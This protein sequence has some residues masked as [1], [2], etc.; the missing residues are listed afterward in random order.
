MISN[1]VSPASLSAHPDQKIESVLLGFVGASSGFVTVDCLVATGQIVRVRTWDAAACAVDREVALETAQPALWIGRFGTAVAANGQLVA[2]GTYA[3]EVVVWS[4]ATG[5][6]L[7]TF[8]DH[9]QR[10]HSL[11]PHRTAR[12]WLQLLL[13]A[14]Q[15]FG[16]LSIGA[17]SAFRLRHSP[18]LQRFFSG[19]PALCLHLRRSQGP[20]LERRGRQ[21]GRP[22]GGSR[23]RSPLPGVFA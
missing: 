6:L 12:C 23:H 4:T 22:L 16:R 14:A 15:C 18:D 2:A 20:C 19:W 7:Q 9:S 17:S 21:A 8:R 11:I 13:T 10:I 1:P 3:G 5:R